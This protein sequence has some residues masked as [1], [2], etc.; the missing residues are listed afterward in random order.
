[1]GASI[2]GL[3]FLRSSYPPRQRDSLSPSSSPVWSKIQE[4]SK[5]V[6]ETTCQPILKDHGSCWL[7][8]K[9]CFLLA[10]PVA[11][12]FAFVWLLWKDKL[13]EHLLINRKLQARTSPTFLIFYFHQ[14]VASQTRLWKFLAC[15]FRCK[16]FWSLDA[17]CFL[18]SSS[19]WLA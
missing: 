15:Y 19:F 18:V 4:S 8:C 17:S 3:S 5:I 13:A 12:S 2:L 11:K 14:E 16:L 1:M 7:E 6:V 9:R 10:T